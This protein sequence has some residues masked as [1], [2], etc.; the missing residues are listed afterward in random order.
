MQPDVWWPGRASCSTLPIVSGPKRRRRT[1]LQSVLGYADL[2][3]S[4]PAGA[5]NVEQ[6]EDL[7]AIRRGAA[8]MV[9]LIDQNLDLFRM[10]AG[11]L[12]L[13]RASVDL[14]NLLRQ[15]CQDLAP[16]ADAKG[17]ALQ[18]DGAEIS[19]IV[20]DLG[21]VYQMLL[22]LV[23]NAVKFTPAGEVRL[24]RVSNGNR[25]CGRR[26]RYRDRHR[27]GDPGAHL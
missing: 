14:N 22:N 1:P 23:A 17:I 3:L 2:L 18:I 25:G 7:A 4:A 11:H 16:E 24:A 26:A 27:P 9:T 12:V 15:V 21:R 5:L 10:K 20:G 13:E 19:S 6:R 8:R